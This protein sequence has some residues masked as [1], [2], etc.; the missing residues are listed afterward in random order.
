MSTSA[1]S[2]SGTT[3]SIGGSSI[4][5]ITSINVD[6][7]SRDDIESTDLLS[8]NNAKTFFGGNM[9]PGTISLE[10]LFEKANAAVV[11]A[12]IGGTVDNG[13]MLITWPDGSTFSCDGYTNNLGVTTPMSDTIKQ[14]LTIKLSGEYTFTAGS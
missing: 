7:I 11:F 9:D 4:A 14:T 3:F 6:G 2:G 1:I 5:E 12:K 10:L 8:T 13:T